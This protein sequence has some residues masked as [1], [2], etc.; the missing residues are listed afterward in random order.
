M[1]LAN[2]LSIFRILLIPFFII[3]LAYYKKEYDVLRWVALGIFLLAMASDALD[4]YV[5]RRW[6]E[7]TA[8]GSFLDPLADK[9]LLTSAF[10]CLYINSELSIRL[11]KWVPIV[12][13][14]RDA[15]LLL[16]SAIVYLLKNSLEV[17]PTVTGKLTTFFQ[18]STVVAVLL[19]FKFSFIIWSVMMF[20]TIFSGLDYIVK[21]SRLFNGGNNSRPSQCG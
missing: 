7:K 15:I 20:F 21:G 11:P 1:G 9:L 6:H 13:I 18:M 12:V 10:V 17:N 19:Q 4:G 8:L 3:V 16:G 14:S 5:A 2:K